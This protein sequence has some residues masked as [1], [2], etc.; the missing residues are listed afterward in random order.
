M[1]K[2]VALVSAV[3]WLGIL[4]TASLASAAGLDPTSLS[5]RQVARP[6]IETIQ[7]PIA[8]PSL[9]RWQPRHTQSP[10]NRFE[11]SL[12][13]SWIVIRASLLTSHRQ[14]VEAGVG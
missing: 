6:A 4:A 3:L 11:W 1:F 8:R 2:R 10:I 14:K 9:I 13:F 12:W 7:R 5:A